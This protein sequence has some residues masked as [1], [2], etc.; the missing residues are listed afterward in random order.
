MNQDLAFAEIIEEMQQ[1]AQDKGERIMLLGLAEKYALADIATMRAKDQEKGEERLGNLINWL[2]EV[3]RPE[4]ARRA[5]KDLQFRSE[6]Y[7]E[8]ATSLNTSCT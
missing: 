2:F 6:C 7:K 3:G 5:S 8:Y 1:M 4:D